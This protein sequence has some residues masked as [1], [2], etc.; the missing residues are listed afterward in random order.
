MTTSQLGG[1]RDGGM[2]RG[3]V[4]MQLPLPPNMMLLCVGLVSSVFCFLYI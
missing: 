1:R 2:G 4:C 3:I